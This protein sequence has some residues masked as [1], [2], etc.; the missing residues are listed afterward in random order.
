MIKNLLG[1]AIGA[2]LVKGSATV[3]TTAGA[4][5]GALAASTIPFVLSRLSIPA[6][7][8]VGAGAYWMKR[9]KDE[10]STSA[11]SSVAAGGTETGNTVSTPAPQAPNVY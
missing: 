9:K 1:A 8:A 4:A 6:M 10:K 5:T 11:N 7:L 2:K 3:G